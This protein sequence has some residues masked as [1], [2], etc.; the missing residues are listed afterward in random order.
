M[1]GWG[2]ATLEFL[3]FPE[4]AFLQ[5]CG[6]PGEE[7]PG[8]QVSMS[9]SGK[10]HKPV[11][12]IPDREQRAKAS[13]V[14][15]HGE[16]FIYWLGMEPSWSREKSSP[17]PPPPPTQSVPGWD[18]VWGWRE[19]MLGPVKNSTTSPPY[20]SRSRAGSSSLPQASVR[21]GGRDNLPPP[22]TGLSY[23]LC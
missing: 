7:S 17:A 16:P 13:P 22:H 14:C 12:S 3:C 18:G 2:I 11:W 8:S 1:L 5:L 20:T 21:L 23:M 19:E 6:L 15:P 10:P 4:A 9:L